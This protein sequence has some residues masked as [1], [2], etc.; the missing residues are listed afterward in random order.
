MKRIAL[1]FLLAF[2]FVG[3]STAD[4]FLKGLAGAEDKKGPEVKGQLPKPVKFSEKGNFGYIPDRKYN[5]MTS[6]RLEDESQ[7]HS[8]AGS[9]WA[10]EG[11]GSYLFA[12]NILRKK[13][14]F[15]KVRLEGDGLSQVKSKVKVISR[16][17]GKI[18]ASKAPRKLAS[19]K[20]SEGEGAKEGQAE[21]AAAP[22]PVA[23]KSEPDP[24]TFN[25]KEI[26]TR[27]TE[28]LPDGTFRVKGDEQFMIGK[29]LYKVIMTGVI[30]PDD[31]SDD[32]VSSN[33]IM[34]SQ[35]EVVNL[36]RT[37]TQ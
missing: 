26:Q 19:D 18:E 5:R 11:Q 28:R 17:V 20:P 10:M 29:N 37:V 3:C 13:G 27:I 4:K 16:L 33:K 34:D 23:K 12:Q 24:N 2:S 21:A 22:K 15:L 8:G 32:G 25:V 14:D 7:L 9:L 1:I 31:F 36:R 30:R 35:Y 6:S